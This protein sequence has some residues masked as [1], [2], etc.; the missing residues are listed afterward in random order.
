MYMNRLLVHYFFFSRYP[1]HRDLHSFPTRRS[2]DLEPEIAADA[3]QSRHR[4]RVG[5]ARRRG[6]RRIPCRAGPGSAVRRCEAESREI[7]RAHA[8]LQSRFDLVCRLLL[9]KKNKNIIS[10]MD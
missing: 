3:Q 7:G 10:S 1:T 6:A 2:S 4:P 8:E 9:E 5:R